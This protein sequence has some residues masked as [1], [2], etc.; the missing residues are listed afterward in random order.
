MSPGAGQ[1]SGELPVRIIEEPGGGMIIVCLCGAEAAVMRRG[2]D[3]G[4][5]LRLRQSGYRTQ[6]RSDLTPA[7]LITMIIHA[8]KCQR[9]REIR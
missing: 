6:I 4:E 7:G 9:A 2:L 5:L 8:R 1:R 3:D